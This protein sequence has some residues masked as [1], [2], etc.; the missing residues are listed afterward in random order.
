MLI[1]SPVELI[2]CQ[3]LVSMCL[4]SSTVMGPDT[5]STPGNDMLLPPRL[6]HLT[7]KFKWRKRVMLWVTTVKRFA[8][9]GDRRAK[10]ILSALGLTLNNALD[11]VFSSQVEQSIA[12]GAIDLEGDDNEIE[13]TTKQFHVVTSIIELVSKDSPTDGIR[14]LVNMMRQVFNC[15]RKNVEAPDQFARRFQALALDYLNHCDTATIQQDSQN[16][17]IILLENSKISPSVYS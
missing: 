16:F 1:H 8:K 14:K 10:G 7:D 17:A 6:T 11:Q 15:T 13:N 9:G 3:L 5:G 12:A 4:D 2:P